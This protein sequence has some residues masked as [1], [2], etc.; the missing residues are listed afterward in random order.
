DSGQVKLHPSLFLL[1]LVLSRLY[2]S[3]MDGS[4]SPLGLAPFMPF[5]IRCGHSAVYRTREMAA[6]ALV[7]FVLV[8]QVPSTVHA[9]LQKLPPEPGPRIQHNHIHGTLLQVLFLL[10][11]YQTDSHRPL[12]AGNGIGESLSQ[13]MW[14]ASRQ[15][16]CVVTRGA[17]LDVL[18][19]LCGPKVSLLEDSQVDEL[20][21][22]TLSIL[23][24]SDLVISDPSSITLGPGSTQ[25]LLSLVRVALSASME[26]PELWRA[27]QLTTQLLTCLLQFPQYEV[28]ELALQGL[29]RRLQEDEEE[30]EKERRHQWLE[31]TTLSN[32]TGM[33]LD[34]T[35]PQCQAKV[36][37]VLCVF[38]SSGEL[39]WRDGAQ[40]LSQEEVLLHLLTLAQNSVHSVEL[41]CAALTLMSQLVNSDPKVASAMFCFAQWG[42][43]V[44]SCCSEEQP[45]EVKLMAAKVLVNSTEALLTNP[46]L[47]LGLFTTVSLWRSLFTLLQDED[48]EV[49]DS[50]SDFIANVPAPLLSKD[51]AG[52]SVC[53]PVALDRGVGLLCRLFELWEQVPAGVLA[54]TE[55]L[56]GDKDDNDEA[57]ADDASSLDEEDFLF[58]KGDL[59]LWAEP[60]QWVKL[61][62][63]HLTSLIPTLKQSQHPGA[64]ILDQARLHTLS[65]QAQTKA[66]S[67]Q[68]ALDSLPALPQFSCTAEH[69]RLSLWHQRATLALDV[70]ERLK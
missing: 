2:P 11:S 28:R 18:V 51:M 41:Q 49:R 7:P 60:V 3:P 34:E 48:H 19:G 35:H 58:E 64:V 36:L 22:R 43:L 45:A 66:L 63:R 31:E 16:S 5:I 13:R 59:N 25:Y 42:A 53:P 1:L 17:F 14:L 46:H 67:S 20:R 8:T 40:T 56:L 27:P 37:Q 54:L 55:W 61:L 44:C 39:L 57:V 4:S 70:L 30:E 12:P 21:Q 68:Q 6:R 38:S 24:D 32:L 15:N 52:V 33:A 62:H 23:M 26:I 65:A 29:L 69:A 47:P 9:L 50:A 10:R